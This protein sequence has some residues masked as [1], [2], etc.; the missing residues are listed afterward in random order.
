[1]AFGNFALPELTTHYPNELNLQHDLAENC[2]LHGFV[3][4]PSAIDDLDLDFTYD[5]TFSTEGHGRQIV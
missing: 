2:N 4:Q 5:P 3:V 1:V